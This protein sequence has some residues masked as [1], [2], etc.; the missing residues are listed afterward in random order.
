MRRGLGFTMAWVGATIV[1]V[2]VAAAAVGSVRSQVTE[3]PT[4][5]G[6]PTAVA[7]AAD[8]PA[9]DSAAP[10]AT[11]TTTTIAPVDASAAEA[12]TPTTSLVP[13]VV[14]TTTLAGVTATS[15]T[16]AT[17]TTTTTQPP[18]GVTKSYTTAAGVVRIMVSGE[19]VTFAG[20]TAD[21][22]WT[23]ELEKAG[24]PEV[25][26]HF[27]KNDDEED[28]VEFHAKFEDGELVVTI[29]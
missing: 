15:T 2:V 27:E 29:S 28:E 17:T 10:A 4:A 11:E 20:A 21:P 23:V 9:A 25:E 18:A 5:L 13:P 14:T 19:S 7:L 1:A 16:A 12:E 8:P 6:A 3:T 24:P 26:V 22:G